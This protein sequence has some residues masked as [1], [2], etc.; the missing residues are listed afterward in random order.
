M[1]QQYE[2]LDIAER[3]K[4]KGR[5]SRR[6]RREG[7]IPAN[8]YYKGEDNLNLTVKKN[9]FLKSMRAGHRIFEVDLKGSNQYVM[10]K[11][12]Q[13]HPVTDDIIHIDL[14]R[15]RRDEKMTISVQLVLEG[16]PAGVKEGGVMMQNL[17]AIDISCL[18]SDVPEHVTIDVS[19]LELHANLNV[20]DIEVPE[21]LEIITGGDTTVVS[22]QLPKEEVEE[23]VP[24]EDIDTEEGEEPEEGEGESTEEAS[25]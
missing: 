4:T 19:E 15:V 16:T 7:L 11:D 25:E 14:M 5:T 3:S 13:Y 17:T 8:Y 20:E 18:P 22:C 24:E 9:N 6:L 12:I 23:E 10:V 1:A 2:H 21:E